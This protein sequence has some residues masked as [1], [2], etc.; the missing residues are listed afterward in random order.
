MFWLLPSSS[1]RARVS[2]K[3]GDSFKNNGFASGEGGTRVYGSLEKCMVVI[4][5][6][7]PKEL[8]DSGPNRRSIARLA[9][10]RLMIF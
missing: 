9:A 10:S 2:M 1:P 3:L 7:V 8:G 4:S 6:K 5:R